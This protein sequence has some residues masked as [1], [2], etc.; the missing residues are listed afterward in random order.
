MDIMDI[1]GKPVHIPIN[2]LKN[3]QFIHMLTAIFSNKHT[4]NSTKS[5]KVILLIIPTAV[6]TITCC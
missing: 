5:F 3:L 2:V 6:S 1:H 4:K